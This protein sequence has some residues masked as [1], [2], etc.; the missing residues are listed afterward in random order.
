[1]PAPRESVSVS[2]GTIQEAVNSHGPGTSFRL[3]PGVYKMGPL[4][5]KD[6]DRFFGEG[7]ATWDG[8]GIQPLAFNSART[9]GVLVSGI[10]FIHFN[11]PNQGPGLFGLNKGESGFTIE[12]CELAEN[13]GTPVVAGNGTRIVNNSIH[14]NDWVGIGGYNISGVV[15]ERNE[16]Y[17]NYLARLSP[18]TATGEA[19][20]IKFVKT[21][22]VT[23]RDNYI[24]DNFGVGVWFDSDNTG[25]LV[26]GNV[27]SGNAFR[28]V[29]DEV[30]FGALIRRNTIAGN[31]RSSGWIGGA[32]VLIATSSGVEVCGN[33]VKGNAQGIVG[34]QQDR[35]S[36]SLGKFVTSHNRVHDNYVS[37]SEGQSGFTGGA[38]RDATNIFDHNHYCLTNEAGFLWGN[39][40]DVKGWRGAGQDRDGTFSCGF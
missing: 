22:D 4:T 20:G 25:S 28:G 1:M 16:I 29:M 3:A 31:G 32:G 11:A 12:G 10:R 26:E 7:R 14:D 9:T 30:S 24:H 5:P 13:R 36:G 17:R 21:S 23:V 27:I 34:F 18:D 37:M 8:G 35:G 19:S 40:T 15:V 33:V 2:P 39:K 38:E 6:G